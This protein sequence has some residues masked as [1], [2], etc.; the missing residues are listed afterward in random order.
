MKI[1]PKFSAM[2]KS[3]WHAAIAIETAFVAQYLVKLASTSTKFNWYSFAYAALAAV[4]APATRA[5]VAK[6]PFLS[7]FAIRITTKIAQAEAAATKKTVA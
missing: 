2:A 1:S 6:Y 7:P 5:I 3:Y 4:V